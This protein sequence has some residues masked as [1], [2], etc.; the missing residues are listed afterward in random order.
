MLTILHGMVWGYQTITISLYSSFTSIRQFL[1]ILCLGQVHVMCSKIT[2]L[3]SSRGT[4]FQPASGFPFPS[5][6]LRHVLESSCSP[7]HIWDGSMCSTQPVLP[8]RV[9]CRGA[10]TLLEASLSSPLTHIW[11]YF[12]FGFLVDSVIVKW[13]SRGETSIPFLFQLQS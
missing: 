5:C 7:Q 9:F 2:I 6:L 13:V 4:V 12:S 8:L 10:Q 11:T 3:I 1:N